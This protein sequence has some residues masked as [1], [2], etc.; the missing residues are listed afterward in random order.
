M[1]PSRWSVRTAWKRRPSS[2]VNVN[3]AP[4]WAS[5]RRTITRRPGRPAGEVE[6]VG[7]FGDLGAVVVAQLAVLGEGRL[8]RPVGQS[9]DRLAERFGERETDRETDVA[10][11]AEVQQLVRGARRVGAHQDR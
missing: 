3:C 2:S 5:S 7:E 11:V 8:P 10:V 1:P 4:G 6:P 9:E